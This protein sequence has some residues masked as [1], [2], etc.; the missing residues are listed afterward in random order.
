[1][2]IKSK[3]KIYNLVSEAWDI[4]WFASVTSQVASDTTSRRYVTQAQLDWLINYY[5][6]SSDLLNAMLAAKLNVNNPVFTGIMVG[7]ELKGNDTTKQLFLKNQATNYVSGI[8]MTDESGGMID[9]YG[10]FR[11]HNDMSMETHKIVNLG[12]PTIGTD[13]TTKEYVDNL[14]AIGT[15]PKAAVKVASVANIASLSGLVT[16]DGY[17]LIAGD[18]IL[19]KNQTTPSQNGIY[20]ASSTAWTN[21]LRF[22]TSQNESFSGIAIKSM[23]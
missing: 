12:A 5:D 20:T 9:F 8:Q 22:T 10:A 21:P 23:I 6:G 4:Y 16:V 19:L 14:V 1:M 17:T 7:P 11:F 2:S 3:Y 13:A 15:K 18:R